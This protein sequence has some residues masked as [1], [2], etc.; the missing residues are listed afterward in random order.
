MNTRPALA[1][2]FRPRL[3]AMA[4]MLALSLIAALA[5]AGPAA[6]AA[7]N[8]TPLEKT[9]ARTGPAVVFV[10]INFSGE[11]YDSHFKHL[12]SD[13]PITV[14]YSC[15][16]FFVNGQ[17]YIGTAGH[18]VTY[19][20]G[21]EADL[22]A[23]AADAAKANGYYKV[24]TTDEQIANEAKQ[25]YEVTQHSEPDVAVFFSA[26]MSGISDDRSLSA[27]IIAS[28]PFEDGDVALLKVNATNTPALPLT[29][30]ADVQVGE[31]S[32]S[33]GYPQ[34]INELQAD[35][36]LSPS[37]KDGTI[38]ALR[39]IQNGKFKVYENSAATGHGMSGGPVVNEAGDVVGVVSFGENVSFNLI[40]PA[41]M[42]QELLN[43][44]GV[45][46]VVDA[47]QKEY[48]AGLDA[49][50]AGKRDD[51]IK[52]FDNVLATVPSH[53]F[54]LRYRTLAS[55]LPKPSASHT[56]RNVLIGL[57][58]LL[59]AAVAAAAV[60][61]SRRGKGDN[62]SV[63]AV[64]APVPAKPAPAAPGRAGRSPAPP[65]S[66]A[67]ARGYEVVVEASGERHTIDR[68]LVIGREGADILIDDL[69][70][71]R[72]HATIRP[73]DNGGLEIADLDSANGTY[74]NDV[75]VGGQ[76]VPLQSGDVIRAGGSVLRVESLAS[77]TE[78]QR[79]PTVIKRK[80]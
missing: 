71:S 3:V 31:P 72:R 58:V 68:R 10:H 19:D 6:A 34:E 64:G 9:A 32:V 12:I 80:D 73:L 13:K 55:A 54:A 60:L 66:V 76:P 79:L 22:I 35:P 77:A 39:T 33:I 41:E 67:T 74:V 18:C 29:P 4:A 8:A 50:Y 59:L 2:C 17:G 38:S 43:S 25:Y 20:S 11:V 65:T 70:A 62:G 46:N 45:K 27:R 47:T 26:Q 56:L 30:D 49:Y 52:H 78:R 16:G 28:K 42:M 75:R 23:A 53:S 5:A 48:L 40:R 44:Q 61:R 14:G 15:T 1:A 21:V 69:E 36:S 24:G 51:A 7:P 63:A 57:A 37:F